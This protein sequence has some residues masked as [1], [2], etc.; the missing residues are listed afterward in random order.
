[1]IIIINNLYF[2]WQEAINN[3]KAAKLRSLL[4]ILGVL[5]GT[6]SVV[7]MVSSGKLATR[8]ALAQFEELGTHLLSATT[9]TDN[10]QT[11]N[12]Q[13]TALSASAIENLPLLEPNIHQAAPYATFFAPLSFESHHLS[14]GVIGVDET[15]AQ[16]AKLHLA[17]GRL[18]SHLDHHSFYCV[19]GHELAQSLHE[20]GVTY[21][22]G[23]QLRVG[24]TLLTIVGILKPWPENS[25][26]N[27]DVNQSVLVP[28]HLISTLSHYAKIN[29]MIF[30]LTPQANIDNTEKKISLYLQELA[31]NQKL[32]FRSAK[33]IIESMAHQQHILSW[34][35]GLIGG[36]S[37]LVGGIGVMNIMLVSVVERK[38]EIGIRM[39]VGARSGDIQSLF[40]LESIT[41]TTLG[42]LLGVIIGILITYI[43]T[44]FTQWNFTLF[45]QPPLVG[46]LVSFMVGI[47]F[48]YYP[49]H[50]AA[51]CDPIACLRNE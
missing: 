49:A 11:S 17:D 22:L 18:I 26:F 6:A 3:I 2:S 23:Q 35:L 27:E 16:L 12:E 21:L 51:K 9:Y 31:P 15:F 47:F 10:H 19:I 40:L 25:F 48:G 20:Q 30:E 13:H 7:A 42:G 44:W 41:L 4:A 36:I 5:V 43:I 24:E 28:I 29:N 34:L 39:A 50:Q 1:M 37:L 46:F 32:F 33:Q 45:W 38:R 14:G 8:E